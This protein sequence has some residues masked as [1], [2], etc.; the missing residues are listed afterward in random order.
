MLAQLAGAQI[1]VEN[2]KSEPPA[3]LV[4][5]MHLGSNL[6]RKG[7]YHGVSLADRVRGEFPASPLLRASYP[8]T[9]LPARKNRPSL[10]SISGPAHSH[11]LKRTEDA[12]PFAGRLQCSKRTISPISNRLSYRTLTRPTTLLAGSPAMTRT[13]RTRYKRHVCALSDSS[14]RFGAAMH[15]P[16]S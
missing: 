10:V 2:S 12:E 4:G 13:H 3:R 11:A 8:G 14:Q 15:V 1:Q 9:P 6:V 16:G 5:L 7:V